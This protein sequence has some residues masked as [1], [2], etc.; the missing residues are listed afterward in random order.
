MTFPHIQASELKI[1]V[2]KA[3]CM[4]LAVGF[5]QRLEAA[6]RAYAE[7]RGWDLHNTGG[8]FFILH[9]VTT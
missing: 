2:Y 5:L 6:G 9:R 1:N 4:A 3:R 7:A 8:A